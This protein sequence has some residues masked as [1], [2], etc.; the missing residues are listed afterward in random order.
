MIGE[1]LSAQEASI[2]SATLRLLLALLAGGLIGL[3]REVRRQTAGLR[4][5]ILICLGSCLLMILSI[6]MG[7][8]FGPAGDAGRIA[9]QVVSGI[10]FLGAGAFI[11]IGNN[12]KGMTTAA[13]IWTV[14]AIGLAI[15]AG[16]WE[17]ALVAF[18]IALFTLTT[19]E[20]VERRFFPSERIKLLQIACQEGGVDRK[21]LDGLL[22]SF[23]VIVQSVDAFQAK[24][25]AMRLNLL[26]RA[27]VDLDV[28]R[29]FRD[30][31]ALG[32]IAKVKLQ[33][34]Y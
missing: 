21:R 15:G 11:K 13:S 32:K 4:T 1:L 20:A 9:A 24:D 33:E 25:K 2:A 10:G 34:K 3:E 8:S 26:V 6:W 29:L 23:K 28:E 27:P 17:I 14:S 5:H 30:I 19:L 7:R 18:G 16:M 31:K 12:V 22:A